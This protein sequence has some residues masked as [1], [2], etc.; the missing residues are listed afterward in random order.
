MSDSVLYEVKDR[1]AHIKLNRPAKLNAFNLEMS[2]ALRDTWARFENDREALVAIL[3]S[4][5]K[6]FSAGVDL[7]DEDRKGGKP[8]MY[9]EA[10]PRNGRTMFKPIVGAIQGYALGQGYLIACTGCDITVAADTAIFGY[11][12][13]KAGVSQI[14]PEY[15]PYMPFKIALEFMLLSWKGGRLMDAQRAYEVGLVNK[16]VPEDRVMDA[17]VEYAEMLKQVPPLFIKSVKY[18]YYTQT[19]RK[20]TTDEIEYINYILPQ[21]IS[22]DRQEAIRAFAEKRNPVFKGREL[23]RLSRKELT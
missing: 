18:G 13:S 22:E 14:P 16:V 15:V 21:E 23:H 5:S 9:H 20:V 19:E 11:P 8:W 17:A 3:S 4:T 6:N 7:T 12:E 1:I 2:A 10:Y